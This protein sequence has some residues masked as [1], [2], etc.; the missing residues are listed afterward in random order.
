MLLVVL[1]GLFGVSTSLGVRVGRLPARRCD[2]WPP[3]SHMFEGDHDWDVDASDEVRTGDR[4]LSAGPLRAA[5]PIKPQRIAGL[6]ARTG[7]MVR[8]KNR[9]RSARSSP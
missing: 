4:A 7:R 2:L 9:R 6:W 5:T 8:Q 1:S 3:N